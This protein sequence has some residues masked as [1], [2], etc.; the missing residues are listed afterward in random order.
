MKANRKI[1]ENKLRPKA[2]DG[3]LLGFDFMA[4][5]DL[6]LKFI[7]VIL[8]LALSSLGLI[9]I[10]D[11]IT[12]SAYFALKTINISG[13]ATLTRSQVISQAD[14]EPGENVLAINLKT[15][16]NRLVAHAWIKDA[17]VQRQIPSTLII[18]VVEEHAV[19]RAVL[20]DGSQ[21]L[22]D[23][24]GQ[25]FKP[26]EP[27]KEV[28]ISKLPRISGLGLEFLG[29]K[30]GFKGKLH[31]A[32][33][34]LLSL[35]DIHGVNEV[36]AD[37]DFGLSISMDFFTAGDAVDGNSIKLKLGF[38]GFKTKLN[39]IREITAYMENSVTEKR[40]RLIDMFNIR[41]VTATLEDK[42]ILPGN[43]KGGV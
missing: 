12:Q 36:T 16:R 14:I 1:R 26:Y 20:E 37:R 7:L 25:P 19:A 31:H 2:A 32:V 43:T 24:E 35:E 9:F 21:V 3:A 6:A 10:H 15:V 18:S 34:D 27:E 30:Y 5:L 11:F 28:L 23:K 22:L 42:V 41:S 4:S 17:V 29:Q 40:L 33:M 39:R 8:I 13:I 38:D